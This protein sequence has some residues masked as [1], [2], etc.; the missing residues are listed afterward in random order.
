MS[1]P[2]APAPQRPS[3]R[4][5]EAERD[6]AAPDLLARLTP[7]EYEKVK[8]ASTTLQFRAGQ[9]V[10]RQGD[11]H[12][13]MFVIL[14]GEVRTYY[15]GPSGREI[16]LAYWAP[17]NFVGGPAIFGGGA[18]LWSGRAMRGTK[19]LHIRGREVR[20]LMTEI[21]NLAIGLVEALEHKGVCY[22]TM[23][24][25]LGTRSASERLAQMLILMGERDG[26]R[27]EGG[28][29]IARRLTHDELAKMVGAT[30]QWV[31][32]MLERLTGQG[33]IEVQRTRIV[34]LDETSLRRFA[35]CELE[36]PARRDRRGRDREQM[37]PKPG[38]AQ[39]PPD[40]RM[41]KS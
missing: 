22:S 41:A 13:G 12:Y 37:T 10:F 27:T 31:T 3:L 29:V 38:L 8:A 21:P 39:A 34:I 24:H 23:I 32:A 16:T 36:A 17:G 7:G 4:L 1:Q 15:A 33:L 26:R 6:M 20:R 9:H 30:R 28:L 14:S 5:R 11:P 25:M 19:T 18:H 2:S 40:R 35:G